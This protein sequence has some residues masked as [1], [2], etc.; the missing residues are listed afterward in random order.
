ML[1]L[2]ETLAGIWSTEMTQAP[3]WIMV[4]RAWEGRWESGDGCDGVRNKEE[5][6]TCILPTYIYIFKE[7]SHLSSK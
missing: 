5:E 3:V 2:G 6:Q 4:I 7:L 1:S